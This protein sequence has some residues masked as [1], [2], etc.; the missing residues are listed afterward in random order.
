MKGTALDR[1]FVGH[2]HRSEELKERRER[3]ERRRQSGRNSMRRKDRRR[4]KGR[5]MLRLS[6]KAGLVPPAE[7]GSSDGAGETSGSEDVHASQSQYQSELQ[8][9]PPTS[10]SN[11]RTV[12]EPSS[13][14]DGPTQ[15]TA[16]LHM[17][18]LKRVRE[19][20]VDP[21]GG[22]TC[23]RLLVDAAMRYLRE[24]RAAERIER[25]AASEIQVAEASSSS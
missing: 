10:S 15:D 14:D 7:H 17:C 22:A 24:V 11:S 8:L 9:P 16:Q 5:A 23:E 12:P 4:E 18:V 20:A 21:D 19:A 25:R 3:E 2:I 6:V 1:Y 13:K